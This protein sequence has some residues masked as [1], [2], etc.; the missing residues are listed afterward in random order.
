LAAAHA[1]F[2]SCPPEIGRPEQHA[3]QEVEAAAEDDASA[4]TDDAAPE[5][6]D[7]SGQVLEPV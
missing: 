3:E 5:N 2:A 1:S 4:S 6:A 7:E